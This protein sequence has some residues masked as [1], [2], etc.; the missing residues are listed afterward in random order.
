MNI[1]DIQII[2]KRS[3][4]RPRDTYPVP[5]AHRGRKTIATRVDIDPP[6]SGAA[7]Y[8][9]GR[10]LRLHFSQQLL[11]LFFR[12]DF[13]VEQMHFALRVLGKARVV[14]HH[15]DRRAVAV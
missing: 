11:Q 5:L 15:A 12:H 8:A 2:A 1:V 14:R 6:S 9:R 7:Y 3:T 13:A 4:P 10:G